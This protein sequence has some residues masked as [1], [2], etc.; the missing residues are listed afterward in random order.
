VLLHLRNGQPATRVYRGDTPSLE[1]CCAAAKVDVAAVR[2][3]PL[4]MQWLPHTRWAF[5]P[6]AV[7]EHSLQP[8][9]EECQCGDATILGGSVPHSGA[10][11]IPLL[12][13][14]NA[15]MQQFWV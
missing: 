1:E 7:L 10:P 2:E 11:P 13:R 8:V 12:L 15:A 5:L 3:S 6:R 9:A 4:V 14:H